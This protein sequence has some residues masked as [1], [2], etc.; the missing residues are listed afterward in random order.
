MAMTP[1]F[2]TF[3]NLEIGDRE[4]IENFTKQF[5]PYTEYTFTSLWIGDTIGETQFSFLNNNLVIKLDY[6]TGHWHRGQTFYSF[7][8]NRLVTTSIR[9]L[10]HFLET[11]EPGKL[12]GLVPEHSL[13]NLHAQTQLR[14]VEDQDNADYV[15]STDKLSRYEGH[16]YSDLRNLKNRFIRRY[17]TDSRVAL[18]DL[19]KKED[20]TKFWELSERWDKR[21]GYQKD[22]GT[23]AMIRLISMA[24]YTPFISVGVFVND[25]LVACSISESLNQE[26]W[27]ITHIAQADV[28]YSG[29]YAY[30]MHAVANV[31]VSHGIMFLNYGQDLGKPNLK[32]AKIAFRPIFFLKKF[33]VQSKTHL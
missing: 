14:I 29:V 9:T 7:L 8:G 22:R 30:L 31:L 11:E 33:L 5:P 15:Y 23:E 16:E 26:K 20:Q 17:G 28:R 25:E 6:I 13:H 32:R 12:L 18:L 1:E 3:K 24:N 27:A 21:Q 2:P 10:T 4:V 19:T